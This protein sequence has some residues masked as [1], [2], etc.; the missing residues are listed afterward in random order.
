MIPETIEALRQSTEGLD[1]PSAAT[2]GDG[3]RRFRLSRGCDAI[4]AEFT[5]AR[6]T[7]AA[8]E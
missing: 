2:R 7:R 3:E 1:E 8:D 6:Q 4:T 5:R